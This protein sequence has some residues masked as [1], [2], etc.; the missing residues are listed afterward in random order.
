MATTSDLKSGVF[1][2]FENELVQVVEVEHRTPGN[3]RAFY[4]AKMRNVK[5]GRLVE[6]RFRSGEAVELV[7]V[8]IR[9]LQYLYKDGD[10]IICM[11][12]ETY[13]QI[14]VNEILFGDGAGFLKEG[15]TVT[16]SF[17]EDNVLSALPPTFVELE[18]TYSEPGMKG[19]TVNNVL[20]PA[21][22]ETGAQIKVP[23][24]VNMGD[25]IRIDTRTR[26]YVERVK[27]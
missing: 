4:Q 3:L 10:D 2:R 13:D 12:P 21:T 20:K 27:K 18:V 14:P 9:E 15:M 16:L 11:D 26:E 23:L 25:K 17:E 19:D 8:E 22:L 5:S 6:Y 7:R 1:I 24:F